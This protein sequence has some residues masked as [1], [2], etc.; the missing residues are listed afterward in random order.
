MCWLHTFCYYDKCTLF[1]YLAAGLTAM[2]CSAGYWVGNFWVAAVAVT[3][4]ATVVMVAA[5]TSLTCRYHRIGTKE[6]NRIFFDD[7]EE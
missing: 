4:I 3:G 2:G 5:V 7:A 6:I 1:F